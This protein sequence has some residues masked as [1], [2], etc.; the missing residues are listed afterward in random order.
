VA[1]RLRPWAAAHGL[2]IDGLPAVGPPDLFSQTEQADRS[3]FEFAQRSF[4]AVAAIRIRSGL[5]ME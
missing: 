5:L 4:K 2:A 3:P 1:N